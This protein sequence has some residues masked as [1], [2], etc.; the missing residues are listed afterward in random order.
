MPLQVIKTFFKKAKQPL[1]VSAA[2][3]EVD[4]LCMSE[5]SPIYLLDTWLIQVLV[6]LHY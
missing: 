3:M 1:L 5:Q 4:V 2:I 6:G